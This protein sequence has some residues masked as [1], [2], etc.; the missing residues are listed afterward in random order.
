MRKREWAS[1]CVLNRR[2]HSSISSLFRSV[3][4]SIL[5]PIQC[6]QYGDA[7][8]SYHISAEGEADEGCFGKT[9]GL[10]EPAQSPSA[11]TFGREAEKWVLISVVHSLS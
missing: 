9:S 1:W 5:P 6:N 7:S 11:T 10:A 3:L 8:R 4:P 2:A